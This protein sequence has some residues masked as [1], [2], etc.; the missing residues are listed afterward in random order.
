MVSAG[1]FTVVGKPVVWACRM[2]GAPAGTTLL[3]Q[4]AFGPIFERYSA[5]CD[6]E[7]TELEVKH[8]GPAFAYRVKMNRKQLNAAPPSWQSS[9]EETQAPIAGSASSEDGSAKV[10]GSYDQKLWMVTAQ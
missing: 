3:N 8:L 5:Y 6:L 10:P 7:E 9:S 4:G 1:D 2:G